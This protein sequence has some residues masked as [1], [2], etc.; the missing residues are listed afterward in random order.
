MQSSTV[1]PVSAESISQAGA[2]GLLSAVGVVDF[3]LAFGAAGW[4]HRA[5]A[6]VVALIGAVLLVRG[7]AAIVGALHP[8]RLAPAPQ[9]RQRSLD[10]VG[11]TPAVPNLR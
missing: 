2:G 8:P 6:A 9:P 1:K 7:I 5:G 10:T 4:S 11:S 3:A